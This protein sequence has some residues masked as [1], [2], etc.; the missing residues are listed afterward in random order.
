MYTFC[1]RITFIAGKFSHADNFVNELFNE[2][3]NQT[4]TKKAIFS[5]LTGLIPLHFNDCLPFSMFTIADINQSLETFD[6]KIQKM[7]DSGKMPAI[8]V[9]CCSICVLYF[10]LNFRMWSI[11]HAYLTSEF[12]LNT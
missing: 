7:S 12:Y 4:G 3:N 10:F 1:P 11:P 2:F 9:I 5:M 8:K 6:K